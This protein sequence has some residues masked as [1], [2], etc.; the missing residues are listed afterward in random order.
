MT[1]CQEVCEHRGFDVELG[2]VLRLVV[3]RL[4]RISWAHGLRAVSSDD[5]SASVFP[6]ATSRKRPPG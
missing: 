3:G 4:P 6:A 2:G 5:W 1:L